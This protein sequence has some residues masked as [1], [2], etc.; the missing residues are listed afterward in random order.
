MAREI[1]NSIKCGFCHEKFDVATEDIEWEHINDAGETDTDSD[2]YDFSV[3]QKIKCPNC[4]K[5]NKIL[6]KMK[7]K[8]S[9][10]ITEIEGISME[11]GA[12]S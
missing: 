12:L 4:G 1:I 5:S 9:C 3:S 7:G 8:S 10:D 2:V 6:V 11:F